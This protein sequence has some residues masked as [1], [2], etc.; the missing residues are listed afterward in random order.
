MTAHLYSLF[1]QQPSGK[2]SRGLRPGVIACSLI[3]CHREKHRS[4][5]KQ[6]PKETWR[7]LLWACAGTSTRVRPG[8]NTHFVPTRARSLDSERLKWMHP[9][10]ESTTDC[11]HPTHPPCFCMMTAKG[12]VCSRMMKSIID[13][14]FATNTWPLRKDGRGPW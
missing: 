9:S 14:W 1:T 3:L 12:V 7:G 2:M 4:R 13:V 5:S 8:R 11:I 10:E 6:A